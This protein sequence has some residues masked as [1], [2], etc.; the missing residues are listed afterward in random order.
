MKKNILLL[1]FVLLAGQ[2]SQAQS[3]T[4]VTG[5]NL[6][7]H[8]S[9]AIAGPQG[10]PNGTQSGYDSVNNKYVSS[11]N[12]STFGPHTDGTD[13]TI[14]MVENNG[15][16]GNGQDFGFTSGVSSIWNG[17]IQGNGTTKWMQAPGSFNYTTATTVSE[18]ETAYNAA[19]AT[20]DVAKASENT[21]YLARIRNSQ[22]YVAMRTY[23]VT[24][25]I[26]GNTFF[27]F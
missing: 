8:H 21:V 4:T 3:L 20:V 14:D 9:T 10:Q 15:P 18:I 23:N 27:D 1:T 7:E 12:A 25:K 13:T 16:Y 17:D 22:L 6:Y 5:K 2:S 24:N 26:N 19:L 11:Y